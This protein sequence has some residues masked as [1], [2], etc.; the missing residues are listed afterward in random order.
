MKQ[1]MTTCFWVCLIYVVA[2]SVRGLLLVW[3]AVAGN[4]VQGAGIG[5]VNSEPHAWT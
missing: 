5:L 2:G 1:G 3:K 4:W